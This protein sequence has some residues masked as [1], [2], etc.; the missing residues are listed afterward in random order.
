VNQRIISGIHPTWQCEE[1]QSQ[2]AIVGQLGGNLGAAVMVPLSDQGLALEPP[3][4]RRKGKNELNDGNGDNAQKRAEYAKCES[5]R[6]KRL[7]E[8]DA[9]P[10]G[11]LCLRAHIVAQEAVRAR[12]PPTC[13]EHGAQQQKIQPEKPHGNAQ[14]DE[15]LY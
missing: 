3:D 8:Y 5:D 9:A 11:G 2:L 15:I 12:I 10:Y 1:N 13:V 6:I 14:T 4:C 7:R